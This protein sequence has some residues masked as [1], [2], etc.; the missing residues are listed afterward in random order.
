M[1]Q[2]G[3]SNGL[4]SGALAKAVG[5]SPD[6]IRYYERIGVLPAA[7]RTDSGYRL[8]PASAVDRVRLVQRALCIGFTLTEL[9]EILKVRD[10]G[11]T[12]CQR[13]YQLAR[14]KL[15]GIAADIKALKRTERYLKEVLSDWE[16]R[17]QRAGR[18]QKSHL[19]HSLGDEFKNSPASVNRFRR[20]SRP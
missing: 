15:N 16:D 13:V 19:L 9:A 7:S 17:I 20:K 8:Y 18:G 4:R 14:K 10:A 11:G 1:V 12:P 3:S 6:T 2:S 5:V